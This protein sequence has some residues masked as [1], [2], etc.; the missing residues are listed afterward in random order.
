MRHIIRG[1]IYFFRKKTAHLFKKIMKIF[2]KTLTGKTKTIRVE[3]YNTTENVKGRSFWVDFITSIVYPED[4]DG[5]K[6]D[7]LIIRI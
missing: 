4:R 6:W 3:P 7:S 2:V 5:E 1:H